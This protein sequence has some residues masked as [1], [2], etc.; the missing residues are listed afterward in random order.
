MAW[1]FSNLF[2]HD[3]IKS[4]NTFDSKLK[5]EIVSLQTEN[6]IVLPPVVVINRNI[7]LSNIFLVNTITE[8]LLKL[9]YFSVDRES[10]PRWGQPKTIKL[11]FR[12]QNKDSLTHGIRIMC[13][14]GTH[15]YSRLLFQWASTK[16]PTK[17]V[18]LVQSG[19]HHHLIDN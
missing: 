16:N 10:Q 3:L 1:S 18:G 6:R 4:W 9:L 17:R 5:I 2:D 7:M 15:V 12:R 8:W 19:H 11:V 13:P 14:S